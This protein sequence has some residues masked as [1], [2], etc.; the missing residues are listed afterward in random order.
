MGV[1]K[2]TNNYCVIHK[3]HANNID[4]FGS[5]TTLNILT[6]NTMKMILEISS[7]WY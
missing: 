4:K 3:L 5:I 7:G 2:G 1:H 6:W